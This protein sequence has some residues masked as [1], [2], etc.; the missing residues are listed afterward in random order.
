ML[1]TVLQMLGEQAASM[2]LA[3]VIASVLTFS[4]TYLLMARPDLRDELQVAAD[5]NAALQEA[6]KKV[7][8]IAAEHFGAKTGEKGQ[9]K[10]TFAAD[11]ADD[12]FRSVGIVGDARR[13]TWSRLLADLRQLAG[14]LFPPKPKDPAPPAA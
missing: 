8:V 7:A 13:I 12:A 11:V 6:V 3:A 9:S 10:L 5:Y 1:N 2:A 4:L 14:M